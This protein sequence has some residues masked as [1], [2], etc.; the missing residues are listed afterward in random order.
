[1]EYEGKISKMPVLFV[2]GGYRYFLGKVGIPEKFTHK[3]LYAYYKNLPLSQYDKELKEQIKLF[4]PKAKEYDIDSPSTFNEWI[5]HFKVSM[6][7][8]ELALKTRLSDKYA[9]REWIA[10]KIGTKHLIPLVGGPWKRGEDID[11]DA[12]PEKFVLKANH[13]S[14]M[15]LVVKD[16]SKLDKEMAVREC[17]KWINTLFGWLGI[18]AYFHIPKCIIAEEY[19][20]Q[21]NGDLMDYKIHCF[22]GRPRIIQIIWERDF[23]SHTAKEAFFDMDWKRGSLMYHTYEQYEE[24]PARPKRLNEMVNIAEKLSS[25]FQYVRVDLYDVNDKIYFGEMTFTPGNGFGNWEGD[26][27][28]R[29]V[30][31]MMENT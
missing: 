5:Q 6:T 18:E 17:N 15:N 14:G 30:G 3:K 11:F 8:E 20:E 9:V 12:L 4:F 16:K 24:A 21:S 25:G 10:S 7:E 26:Y 28:E 2:K 23:Q 1:M 22:H 31:K 27:S 13:G 19:I 29:Y